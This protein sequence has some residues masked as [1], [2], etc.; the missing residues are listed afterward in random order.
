MMRAGKNRLRRSH[1]H[2]LA[3]IEHGDAVGQIA[4]HA[5]IMRDEDVADLFRG[6]QFD[7]KIEDRR[8]HRDVERRGR[9]VAD[10]D[11]RIAGKGPG[12]GDALL[13]TS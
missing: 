7:Q 4:H 10:N 13:E 11:P 6:L 5:E 9:F 3:K 2:D 1:F 8:L 12:N